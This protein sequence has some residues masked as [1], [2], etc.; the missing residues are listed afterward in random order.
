M[1]SLPRPEG[2]HSIT[3]GFSVPHAA[4]VVEFMEKAFGGKVVDRYDGPGGTVAHCEVLL[5]DSVVMLGETMPGADPMP[6]SLSYYV[7]DAAAVDATYKRAL[8]AG[9]T[10]SAPPANQFYG[11]RTASVK[12]VGGNKWTIC[13]VIERVSQE[14]MHR[15]MAAM[16]KGSAS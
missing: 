16:M 2:H 15:R 4:K 14:E 1:A 8:A 13:A 7:A 6:A 12:D 3:P 9:A 5:G 10:S 11:Y